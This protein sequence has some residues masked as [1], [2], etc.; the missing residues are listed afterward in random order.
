MSLGLW[1]IFGVLFLVMASAFAFSTVILLTVGLLPAWVAFVV[2]RN[3][4]KAAGKSVMS[5]NLVGVAPYLIDLWVVGRAGQM[6]KA[7]GM[8]TD[9]FTWFVIYGA[10][11]VGWVIYLG[12]PHLIAGYVEM[13]TLQR[14]AHLVRL[15]QEIVEEW[16]EEIAGAMS[17]QG[18]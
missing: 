6:D 15:R 17:R 2:D 4:T 5:L 8:L 10:A 11:A 18:D 14:K 12:M 16:G 13:R 7:Y 9:P 1:W 3:P